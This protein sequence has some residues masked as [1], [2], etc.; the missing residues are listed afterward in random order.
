[1]AATPSK[2]RPATGQGPRWRAHGVVTT[3][4]LIMLG[5]MIVRDL[6]VGR[7]GS[8]ATPSADVTQR[9]L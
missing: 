4:V 2:N 1:M 5:V 3:V 6:L 8:S 9:Q 7:W